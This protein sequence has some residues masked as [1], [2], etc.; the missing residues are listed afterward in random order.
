MVLQAF[1]VDEYLTLQAV[2]LGVAQEGWY[3]TA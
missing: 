3:L 2:K 1:A